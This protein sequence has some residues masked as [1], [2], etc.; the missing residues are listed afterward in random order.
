MKKN[1]ISEIYEEYKIENNI[2]NRNNIKC[3]FKSMYQ[4]NYSHL[5]GQYYIYEEKMFEYLITMYQKLSEYFDFFYSLKS[6]L[7]SMYNNLIDMKNNQEKISFHAFF[8]PGYNDLGGYKDHLGNTTTK[9]LAILNDIHKF[10][11]EENIPHEIHCYYCD[12]YIENC[13]DNVNPNWY[14]ELQVNKDLFH[15]ECQKYFED[16]WIHNTSDLEIFKNEESFGGHIDQDIINNLDKKV[17]RSFYIAN[18]V[19]YQKL[20]F[21]EERIKERN[22]I[23]ATMYIMVSDYINT[24]KNGIYLPMENMYDREKIIANNNTCTM[25]LRQDLVKKYE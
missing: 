10:F 20:D 9:K 4:N 3:I 18:E 7:V 23:L 25:Y 13:D 22:D 24:I 17:Y 5:E 19:F 15:K 2:V 12:S 21:T 14:Q 16:S 1:L 11:K 8:C 6:D